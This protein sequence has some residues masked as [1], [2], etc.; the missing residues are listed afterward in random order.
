MTSRLALIAAAGMLLWGAMTP[1]KAADLGAGCCADLE[2]RVAELEATTAR[3]GNRTVSL[4]VYGQVNKALLIWDDG[5][6]SDAY[7][8]DN[9]RASSRFGLIGKANIKPG[10]TA[11]YNMELEL[12][13][14]RADEVNNGQFGDSYTKGF[15][16]G[17]TIRQNYWFVESDRFGRISVGQQHT[18][19]SGTS[20]VVL[21]NSMRSADPDTG[22]AMQI[23]TT[24]GGNAS[25]YL[26]STVFQGFSNWNAE[27]VHRSQWSEDFTANRIADVIRY[28]SPS[29]YGFIVSAA[30]GADDYA[31]V[32]LRF[33]R[34]F[35]DFRVAGAASYQWDNRNPAIRTE[36]FIPGDPDDP[37]DH[38]YI[39][40]YYRPSIN[41]E[42]LA[43]SF[44]VMHAPTGLYAAFAAGKRD[45]QNNRDTGLQDPSY[46]YAQGGLERKILPYGTT[47]VYAEYGRYKS[48]EGEAGFVPGPNGH[49]ASAQDS[50]ATRIGFGVVQKID[51]AAMDIYA[52]ATIWSFEDNQSRSGQLEYEDL[53]TILIGSRIKF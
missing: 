41:F 8:V 50:E 48:F 4:Q 21:G 19:S 3:K 35:G 15:R 14:A 53:K 30:L 42:V 18:A 1:A 49:A 36:T 12:N 13:D 28:D 23:R 37:D 9:T 17:L 22:S 51:A 24:T 38:G 7:V 20:E 5:I 26:N 32:A 46:W 29:F 45:Y 31:D 39:D 6:D 34:D 25:S 44:S 10:W 27:L 33:K 40:Q 47:T 2:E 16:E 11:G 43:G 52:Q